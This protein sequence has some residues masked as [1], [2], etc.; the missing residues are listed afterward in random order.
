MKVNYNKVKEREDELIRYVGFL[1]MDILKYLNLTKRS[2]YLKSI[3]KFDKIQELN[4]NYRIQY[5]KHGKPYKETVLRKWIADNPQF[6]DCV[7][8]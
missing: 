5:A 3:N 1:P 7:D 6:E 2:D 8:L 4:Y